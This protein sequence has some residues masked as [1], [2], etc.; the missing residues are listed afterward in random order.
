MVRDGTLV[1]VSVC[2]QGLVW[3]E[4][5]A[6]TKGGSTKAFLSTCPDVRHKGRVKG[7]A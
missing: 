2:G 3:F 4:T 1:K 7:E 5:P 6:G